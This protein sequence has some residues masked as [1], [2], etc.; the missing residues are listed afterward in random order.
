MTAMERIG[1]VG[2]GRMGLPMSA[3]LLRKGF[4]LAVFDLRRPPMRQAEALGAEPA[5]SLAEIARACDVV[6]TMLPGPPE[7]A[8]ACLGPDGLLAQA[9]PGTTV[10]NMGTV[11]PATVDAL[12][13]A[14]RK[15]GIGVVDAA[16]GRLVED[17]ERGES[18]FMVGAD[19]G[20][21]RRVRPMLEAMGN[22]IHHAGPVGT[23]T[24]T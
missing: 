2:L 8:A 10:V 16:V 6:F 5:G 20:E 9:R 23:G 14:A 15:A 18:L 12:A 22:R 17:A 24:R 19:A 7:V 4:A 11:D 13:A 1:F 3:N 21:L